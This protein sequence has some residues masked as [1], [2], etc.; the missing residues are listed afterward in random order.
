MSN[1]VLTRDLVKYFPVKSGV[2]GKKVG[3]VKAVDRVTINIRKE[4]TL[5]L[6]G[7][8][9]CGKTTLAKTIIR[10]YKPD[11]GQI[12]FD[13]EGKI[14]ENPPY[15]G[16]NSFID[17]A[18][19]RGAELRKLRR[20][21]QIVYQN[22]TTS[23]NPRMLVK[24]IVAEPLIVQGIC[25]GAEAEEK[26]LEILERVGLG[27]EHLYRYPHEFSGGQRQR[28]AIARAL[29]T[30][31][32]FVILDEPTSS[33]DVSVRA[34]LLELFKELQ[35]KMNLTYLFISH[36]LSIIEAISD[37]IAVM[38]LGKVVELAEN[39]EIFSNPLH[40]YTQALFSAIPIPN[41]ES[42]RKRILLPGEPP[43]PVNPPTGCRFHPRCIYAMDIC[44][45]T[46]PKL[47]KVGSEH[48]VA[49]HLY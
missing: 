34:S 20:F 43:S 33:V 45:N 2:F 28:I 47:Q 32:S 9:G 12:L 25:K 37:R 17:L 19:V 10:L 38:Y 48:L 42:K 1:I 49:C 29:I 26:V 31:P 46:E 27:K 23:L 22:P 30:N 41:P 36:D 40:P 3:E 7:E 39:K 4:E 21:M 44:K 24:D 13:P 11:Y 6:V 16:K 14:P 8:S 5:G 35:K 15:E 18:K